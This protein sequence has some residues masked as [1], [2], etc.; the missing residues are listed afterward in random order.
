[1]LWEVGVHGQFVAEARNRLA[2]DVAGR[3]EGRARTRNQIRLA[4]M[5]MTTGDPIE[6]TALGTQ[7]LTGRPPYAPA[8]PPTTCTTYAASV[9]RT[10]TSP[11]SPN[12]ATASAP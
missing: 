3:A 6:A 10:P 11:R 5:I 2:A 9:N 12:S 4:S 7:A 8:A 1:M